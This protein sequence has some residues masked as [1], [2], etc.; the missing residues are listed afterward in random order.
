MDRASSFGIRNKKGR[1]TGVQR[2]EHIIIFIG[3]SFYSAA[4]TSSVICGAVP[5][6][7]VR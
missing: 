2:P 5:M 3:K 1:R 6:L 7:N 4:F